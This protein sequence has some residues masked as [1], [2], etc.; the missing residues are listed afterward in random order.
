MEASISEMVE[1]I[2]QYLIMFRWWRARATVKESPSMINCLRARETAN[3][4]AKR[5]AKAFPKDW[6]TRKADERYN[7]NDAPCSVPADC[8]LGREGVSDGSVKIDIEMISRGC[9]FS[10]G[11]E[12]LTF[13]AE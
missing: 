8:S 1:E 11:G 9:H 6:V 13:Q 3:L 2:L 10:K 12:V 4:A 5:A 7:F